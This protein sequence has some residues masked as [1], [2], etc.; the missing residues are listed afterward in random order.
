M[1]TWNGHWGGK[2]KLIMSSTRRKRAHSDYKG[3]W[4]FLVQFYTM[5][6]EKHIWTDSM[7]SWGPS[8][9]LLNPQAWFWSLNVPKSILNSSQKVSGQYLNASP[10]NI[11]IYNLSWLPLLFRCP[12]PILKNISH[13]FPPGFKKTWAHHSIAFI[14]GKMWAK[15][16]RDPN[17]FTELVS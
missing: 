17:K 4:N 10:Q 6:H 8:T 2:W 16:Q 12:G 13:P 15:W 1:S 9:L 3:I 14:Q 5:T 7:V 11:S